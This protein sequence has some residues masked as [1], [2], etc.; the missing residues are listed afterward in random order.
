MFRLLAGTMAE[1]VEDD[2]RRG[3]M[4]RTAGKVFFLLSLLASISPQASTI[5]FSSVSFLPSYGSDRL[6]SFYPTI[7]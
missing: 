2:S 6:S 7:V 1:K 3:K 4:Q 5:A